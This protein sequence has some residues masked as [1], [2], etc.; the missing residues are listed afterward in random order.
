M[1]PKQ[2][3]QEIRFVEET[4]STNMDLVADLRRGRERGEGCWLVAMRQTAGRG[5]QGREWQ[6][7]T[8]NFA[9][10]TLVRLGPADPPATTLS[11]LAGLA[12]YDTAR[13]YM[14]EQAGLRLKW[15]NDLEHDGCKLSGI[16][17][18]REGDWAVIG[19]GVNLVGAPA[20][21]GRRT[22]SFAALGAAPAIRSFAE[23]LADNFA[24]EL[25]R[26]RR[27]GA[28]AVMARW[29]AAAHSVGTP[30]VVHDGN[31][32]RVAGTFAGL[33][34]D[35]SLRLALGEGTVRIIHAGD[36]EAEAG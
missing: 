25:G 21:D 28:E 5:R 34:P 14:P 12:L 7:A 24:F 33:E 13:E 31:A 1:T 30:L 32:G 9:G 10:T 3:R 6:G 36:I 16:L 2:T 29:L 35:G 22:S 17:L 26:W 15:P 18:E 4:A 20:I 8:G 11:L 27:Y 23:V 19:F